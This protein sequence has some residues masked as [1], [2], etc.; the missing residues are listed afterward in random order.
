MA[1]K[2]NFEIADQRFMAIS[3]CGPIG[4]MYEIKFHMLDDD[5]YIYAFGDDMV[6]ELTLAKSSIYDEIINST[7]EGRELNSP[8]EIESVA[9]ITKAKGSKYYELFKILKKYK[10]TI[11][12]Q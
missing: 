2:I 7:E 3:A 10:D 5:T 1:D 12:K 4:Y 11:W 8:E 6:S 9:N